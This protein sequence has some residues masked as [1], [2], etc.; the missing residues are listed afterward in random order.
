MNQPQPLI[1]FSSKNTIP[2]EKNPS[3]YQH[4]IMIDNGKWIQTLK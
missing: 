1:Y 4:D 2:I 3:M